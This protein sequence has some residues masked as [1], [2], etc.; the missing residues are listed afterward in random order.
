MRDIQRARLYSRR[1][2]RSCKSFQ[3]WLKKSRKL[4]RIC[5]AWSEKPKELECFRIYFFGFRTLYRIAFVLFSLAA[6]V[7]S[8]YWYCGCLLYI[9]LESKLLAQVLTAISRS[10]EPFFSKLAIKSRCILCIHSTP[11]YCWFAARQ[12]FIVF[13]LALSII[14]MYAVASLVFFHAYFIEEDGL[15]CATLIQCYATVMRVGLLATL[16]DVSLNCQTNIS[17]WDFFILVQVVRSPDN[18]CQIGHCSTNNW[19]RRSIIR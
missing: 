15:F 1:L 5:S 6:L 2:D 3:M 14:F 9:F 16:A 18:L 7:H 10:G 11:L 17:A 12:L 13:L 8:A 4:Y 19:W